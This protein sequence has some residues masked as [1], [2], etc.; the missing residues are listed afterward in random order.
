MRAGACTSAATEKDKSNRGTQWRRTAL[1]GDLSLTLTLSPRREERRGERGALARPTPPS[2]QDRPN[3]PFSAFENQSDAVAVFAGGG[4]PSCST[5]TSRV[6]S[7][8]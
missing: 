4:L 7:P 6:T 2:T 8:R 1:A 5:T 3:T